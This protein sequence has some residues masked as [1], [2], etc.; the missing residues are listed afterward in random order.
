MSKIKDS[1]ARLN[2]LGITP[3]T[4]NGLSLDPQEAELISKIFANQTIFEGNFQVV[5]FMCMVAE[6]KYQ[7]SVGINIKKEAMRN[8][9]CNAV[10]DAWGYC[11]LLK[12]DDLEVVKVDD[13]ERV[14]VA[15]QYIDFNDREAFK[16]SFGELLWLDP[17]SWQEQMYQKKQEYMYSPFVDEFMLLVTNEGGIVETRPSSSNILIEVY[18]SIL[19]K[20]KYQNQNA[21]T[22]G[23]HNKRR[24]TAAKP[25]SAPSAWKLTTKSHKCKDG[26][27]R[28][29]YADGKGKSAVRCKAGNRFVYKKI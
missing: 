6:W 12:I 22:G 29:V 20:L 17:K 9:V 15:G 23:R 28:R 26:V 1:Y 18:D 19:N 5:A 16:R 2:I 13:V 8:S 14:M 7:L 27:V 4:L 11:Q 25:K 3:S 10:Y 24:V 21:T